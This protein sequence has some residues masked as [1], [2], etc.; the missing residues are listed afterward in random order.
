MNQDRKTERPKDA[1][2]QK[3]KQTKIGEKNNK[4]DSKGFQTHFNELS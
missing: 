4:Q 3:E 1:K 2:K